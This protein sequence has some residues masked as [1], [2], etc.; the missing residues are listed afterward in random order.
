MFNSP[1][2]ARCRLARLLMVL[3]GLTGLTVS[4]TSTTLAQTKI[5]AR[6]ADGF[7]DSMGVNV[8]MESLNTPYKDYPGINLMLQVLGMRHIRDEINDTDPSF[9]DE[10]QRI[11]S[12]G[13]KLCGLIEGGNDYPP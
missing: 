9:V 5:Q 13:Y 10:I 7:V 11:G 12:L 8:H 6:E 4:P 1:G 2:S 3:T